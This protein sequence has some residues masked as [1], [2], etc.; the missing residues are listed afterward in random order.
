MKTLIYIL[1]ASVFILSCKSKPVKDQKEIARFKLEKMWTSDTLFKTPESVY[2]DETRDVIY[3]SNINS[4]EEESENS[5]FMS[6]ISPAGDI[7]EL[8]WIDNVNTPKGIGVFN[9]HL[10]VTET[11]KLVV[12]DI[13]S[14][15]IIKKIPVEGAG[16]LNDVSIDENGIV[17]FTDSK[18]GIIYKYANDSVTILITGI[19]NANGLY[20]EKD[21]LL[22]AASDFLAIDYD[23]Q[24]ISVI[25]DSIDGG[26][27]IA[28]VGGGTYLISEWPGEVFI[29]LPD[30]SI[31]SLLNTRKAEIN[32]ADIDYIQKDS[33]L[34]VPTFF[35][36]SVVAYK[37]LQE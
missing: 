3:V 32:S 25:N 15:K 12:I 17:Y 27:G 24:S 35:K 21:R 30:S 31:I 1:I 9:N 11:D 16:F 5:G 10:F 14:S 8:H 33:I 6:K 19:D 28:E 20:C 34:L 2:Y 23:S 22:C 7:L 13:D 36:N 4:G 29:I 18:T 26:D 37:L